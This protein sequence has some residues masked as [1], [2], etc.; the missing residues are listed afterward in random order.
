MVRH[1]QILNR[2]MDLQPFL[3]KPFHQF[4]DCRLEGDVAIIIWARPNVGLYDQI[5]EFLMRPKFRIHSRLVN[6][7]HKGPNCLGVSEGYKD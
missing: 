2:E 6:F 3:N 1:R 7:K 4:I 5:K